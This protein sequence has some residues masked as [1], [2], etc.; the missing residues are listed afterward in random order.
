MKKLK[1]IDIAPYSGKRVK[2]FH[3]FKRYMS[4]GGLKDEDLS[5]TEI[6]F[7]NKP[8]RADIEVQEGDVLFAKMTNTN[9][10]LLIDK[11]LNGI[12]VSTGFSVHR[13]KKNELD[14]EYLLHYLRHDYFH[15]Q[16]NKLCT[17]AIQSAISNKGIEKIMVP[18]P[19]F[20]DQRHIA[21]ILSKAENLIAQR[22]ESIALLDEFLKSTFLEMFG[23]P[24]R[25]EK[26]WEV[27]PFNDVG[28]FKSGGT[29][30]KSRTDFWEGD[31]PW[32]S[33]KDMKVSKIWDSQD[34]ISEIVFEE[35][36]LK[37]IPRN[38]LLIVVRGMILAHSFPIAINEVEVA[39]NQD[40]KAIEPIK[41]L[42]I[43]YLQYCIHAMKRQILDLISSAG[44]GTR[45]FDTSAMQKLLIPLPSIKLQNQFAQIAE[46][47]ESLKVQY[48]QSLQEFES[49]YGSLS[50]RAFKGELKLDKNEESMLMAAESEQEY[51]TQSQLSIP[52]SKKGFAKLVLAGKIINECK[53]SPEF[54][55]I[56]FQ[57]LQHLAEHLMEA[58]L[59]LN[60]YNQAAGPYDNKF[61]H[62][63]HNKMKQQKWFASRGYKYSPL[64]KSNEIDGHFSRYFGNDNEQ[65]SKLIKLLGK[66][67][68]DQ[69]EIISTLYA[70]WNDRT[71]K[72]EPITNEAII[73]GF[74]NWSERKQ[75]YNFKQ[76]EKAIEWMKENGLEPKGFGELIKH[77]KKKKKV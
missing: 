69:C 48:Q 6:D 67:S 26:G 23:D 66:A 3:G 28:K 74:F 29:P 49:L 57:K 20:P 17:G 36:T 77:S 61:M 15:R 37:R 64:E 62:T 34:H 12:I 31:F 30:S 10:A 70:V 52:P 9:K 76:L 54:T 8:S 56:K 71:I 27:I 47:T 7:A 24:V 38:H 18:V 44:H 73:Q 32:V 4:T 55:N 13:P 1:L 14:G 43:A 39:I 22:K 40:M 50:Q 19:A 11:E 25:N 21:N 60:Y 33:P 72:K 51:Q 53:D 42:N 2:P 41:D 75:K 63:L 68:E 16:K 59:N 65:F 35:T 46:K 58:D 5:F 45:K